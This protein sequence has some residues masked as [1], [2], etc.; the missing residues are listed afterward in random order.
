MPFSMD[1]KKGSAHFTKVSHNKSLESLFVL[2]S[3]LLAPLPA[4]MHCLLRIHPHTPLE[5]ASVS[6]E[7]AVVANLNFC[8]ILDRFPNVKVVSDRS[9]E[10][11]EVVETRERLTLG[12]GRRA[13]RLFPE[14][15]DSLSPPSPSIG[16]PDFWK[17]SRES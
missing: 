1:T 17:S 5:T 13:P 4:L 16:I 10:A 7:N 2:K 3:K 11:E 12:C 14:P 9:E 8:F 6:Y 15:I